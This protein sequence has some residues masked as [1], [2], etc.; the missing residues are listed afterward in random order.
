VS[1]QA[2]ERVLNALAGMPPKPCVNCGSSL[3]LQFPTLIIEEGTRVGS[4]AFPIC[5]HCASAS[6]P[7]P[8]LSW[9]DQPRL[10]AF[11]IMAASE[12]TWRFH[13]RLRFGWNNCG[14]CSDRFD[15]PRPVKRNLG[16]S[17]KAPY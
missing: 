4:M 13:V 2:V 9:I 3:D 17:P 12:L 7:Q 16:A 10:T 15:R 1:M 8:A 6:S 14:N 11:A 5:Y